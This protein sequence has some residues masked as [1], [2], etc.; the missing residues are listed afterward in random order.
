MVVNVVQGVNAKTYWGKSG[1]A[2]LERGA[3]KIATLDRE[4]GEAGKG[5]R[6]IVSDEFG[7]L[8]GHE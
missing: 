6:F 3:D 4:N 8:L 7:V 2:G 1:A 5:S